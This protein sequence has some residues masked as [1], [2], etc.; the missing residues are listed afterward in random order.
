[1]R[2]KPFT[3]DARIADMGRLWRERNAEEYGAVLI[4]A[5]WGRSSPTRPGE[6]DLAELLGRFG[7]WIQLRRQ[8]RAAVRGSDYHRADTRRRVRARAMH[9]RASVA[10]GLGGAAAA[11]FTYPYWAP[12]SWT[13]PYLEQHRLT[14]A[15]ALEDRKGGWIGVVDRSLTARA[16]GVAGA[17]PVPPYVAME[18]A[19][20][21]DFIRLLYA[22]EDGHI[23]SWRSIHGID[24]VGVARGVKS[25][26]LGGDGPG[27][28]SLA[29]QLVRTMD[30]TNP[31]SQSAFDKIQRKAHE[32]K[33]A[34]LLYHSLGGANSPEFQSYLARHLTFV[35]GAPGSRMGTPLHGLELASQVVL[36][37]PAARLERFESAM[38][39]AA[40]KAP[41]ILAPASSP[42]G[43]AARDARWRRVQ[44]RAVR[45][46]ELAYPDDPGLRADIAAVRAMPAPSGPRGADGAYRP[47]ATSGAF[48]IWA[49]PEIRGLAYASG[50][51]RAAYGQLTDA[52]APEEM[53]RLNGIRLTIDVKENMRFK[54][55]LRRDLEAAQG[56]Y[57]RALTGPLVG[58]QAKADV[59]AALVKDG[60]I[61]RFYANMQE[62]AFYG[63][64]NERDAQGR[65]DPAKA[66]RPIGSTG[67]AMLAPLLGQS[68]T[69]ATRYCNK[70]HGNV[71]NAGGKKGGSCTDPRMWLPARAV[72]GHSYNLPL[73]WRLRDVPDAKLRDLADR[74]RLRLP[75]RLKPSETIVLGAATARPADI[76]RMIDAIGRGAA[77]V[78]ARAGLPTIV[79]AFRTQGQDWKPWQPTSGTLDISDQLAKAGAR[80]FVRGVLSAPVERGGTLAGIAQ[81]LGTARDHLGKSGTSQAGN[82]GRD[83]GKFAIGS[84]TRGGGHYAY[85]LMVDGRDPAVGLAST[86][87]WPPLY[88]SL[89]T[90]VGSDEAAAAKR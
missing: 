30:G 29:A 81:A 57:G 82:P 50:E 62:P 5:G 55:R 31:G 16:R 46:L 21:E 23:G 54:L 33:H 25:L 78:P 77:G 59:I 8:A 80:D 7:T 13:A 15:I 27:G 19:P 88:E 6:L 14:E 48:Q 86:L 43:V 2:I 12:S 39:A 66:M 26:L 87:T 32:F 85:F 90:I 67:K 34:P 11:M 63:G 17:A 35:I 58:D 75:G 73:I 71:Q 56:L 37:K 74:Y 1:M 51:L 53:R 3:I 9:L 28:S 36:S 38:F 76:V 69:V 22:L 52:L 40:V 41:I 18:A 60:R 10:V 45:A 65:Y 70:Q 42:E 47:A 44:N 83:R 4:L 68:D 89:R 24:V 49:N 61:V 79:G 84:F 64:W 20:P 72:Y